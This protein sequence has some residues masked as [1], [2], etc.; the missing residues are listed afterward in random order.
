MGVAERDG[1]GEEE[2]EQV[3]VATRRR[4]VFNMEGEELMNNREMREEANKGR[5]IRR[6]RRECVF[7]WEGY[8][9]QDARCDSRSK[10]QIAPSE[11]GQV[12]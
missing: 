4:E 12:R 10:T 7:G 9:K 1:I 2:H 3:R 5:E 6:T 8:W 11:E